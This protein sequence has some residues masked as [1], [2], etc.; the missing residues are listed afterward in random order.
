MRKL[1]TTVAAAALGLAGTAAH[2]ADAPD[3]QT[4][5]IQVKVLGTAVLPSGKLLHVDYIAPALAAMPA[6]AAPQTVL[7]NNA[8]PTLA[9][10]YFFTP[11][12]SVE[13]I[14]C[15][16]AHHVSGDGSLAGTGLV[17]HLLVLPATFTA[18]Y[19]LTGLP[20][21]IK[22]YVG[23]GPA[24]F[25]YIAERPGPTAA[26]LGVTEVHFANKVGA[27]VQAGFD[28]PI[29]HTPFGLSLDVKKYFVNTRVHFFAGSAEV[30]TT[31]HRVSP[32]VASAGVTYRF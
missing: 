31:E 10:E 6:F 23:A 24:W 5:K 3:A 19:H 29:A 17:D 9:I 26:A 2:A 21:G 4:G 32:W 7:N 30:L 1:I 15:F 20:M 14:C 13:T 11:N 25:F 18:K 12:I 22:P 8:V 28:V 16:T 27:A